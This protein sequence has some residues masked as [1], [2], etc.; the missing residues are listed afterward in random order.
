M[1]RHLRGHV[2]GFFPVR[3]GG[4]SRRAGP[5]ARVAWL[6]P[7]QANVAAVVALVARHFGEVAV[8]VWSFSCLR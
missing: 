3:F 6:A 8:F 7:Q 4:Y 2:G 1:F 5:L